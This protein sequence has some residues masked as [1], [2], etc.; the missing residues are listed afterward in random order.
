MYSI[1]NGLHDVD[2]T[3]SFTHGARLAGLRRSNNA[4]LTGIKDS[5]WAAILKFHKVLSM[6]EHQ[7]IHLRLT[8][9]SDDGC[10]ESGH[11]LM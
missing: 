8:A 6:H 3:R 11:T 10:N 9:K 5:P 1:H 2:H 7:R 4:H